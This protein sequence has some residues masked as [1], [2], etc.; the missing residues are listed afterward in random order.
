[1]RASRNVYAGH[2]WPAGRTLRTDDL[3]D[4]LSRSDL[5]WML[6]EKS[7][8]EYC[9]FFCICNAKNT[10]TFII[11]L[12]TNGPLEPKPQLKPTKTIK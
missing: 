5:L 4:V 11:M 1:M 12:D 2:H 3:A 8:S 7:I 6:R 9:F 10:I